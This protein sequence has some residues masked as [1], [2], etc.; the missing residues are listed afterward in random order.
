[1]K[2]LHVVMIIIGGMA[3]LTVFGT[4]II[5]NPVFHD[6]AV[7]NMPRNDVNK[8]LIDAAKN[9]QAVKIFLEKY[10][11]SQDEIEYYGGKGEQLVSFSPPRAIYNDTKYPPTSRTIDLQI[12]VSVSNFTVYEN[13]A[14]M[15]CTIL[16]YDENNGINYQLYP[17]SN[18]SQTL[19]DTIQRNNCF[20]PSVLPMPPSAQMFE[21]VTKMYVT[22][23]Q[24][25]ATLL[26]APLGFSGT[27][28]TQLLQLHGAVPGGI[29]TWVFPP[30]L[31]GN[32]SRTIALGI[33]TSPDAKPGE[34]VIPIT[35]DGW[36]EDYT[37]NT[38]TL[39]E[40]T[41]LAEVHLT[42]KPYSGIGM[43]LGGI[44]HNFRS[45]CV[46]KNNCASGPTNDYLDTTLSSAQKTRVILSVNG[47]KGVWA[48]A[49]PSIITAGPD[50]TVARVMTAGVSISDNPKEN[51]G[52]KDPLVITASADGIHMTKILGVQVDNNST[53]LQGA[54]P[55]SLD[56][57]NVLGGNGGM[58]STMGIVVYDPANNSGSLPVRL[59]VLGS[60]EGNSTTPLPPWLSVIIPTPS[61]LL[62]ATQ[63]YYIP[64]GVL[65]HSAPH[66]GTYH[67]LVSEDVGGKHFVVPQKIIL[68]W[69]VP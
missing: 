28:Y 21:N 69:N 42:V 27:Y 47:P 37:T 1:M 45:F 57:Q 9:V 63:P 22:L 36:V 68:N 38:K 61:F 52:A 31:E 64:V 44:E 51:A 32:L 25:N 14:K 3:T 13:D 8:K 46:E 26:Q 18:S 39:F 62:N 23:E 66:S 29:T 54:S 55:I 10:P 43:H 7:Q 35:G 56:D 20:D 48:K 49:F 34:Y 2:I 40:N 19:L 60:F 15:R 33:S 5:L 65:T 30:Q 53:V 67:I 6:S 4:Y 16:S 11:N 24:G 41:T 17:T 59:A 58:L 12:P 50:G